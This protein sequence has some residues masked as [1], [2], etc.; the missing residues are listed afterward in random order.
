MKIHKTTYIWIFAALICCLATLDLRAEESPTFEG[1]WR[2]FI[3]IPEKGEMRVTIKIEGNNY[4]QYFKSVEGWQ[5]VDADKSYFETGKDMAMVGWINSGGVWT[6]NQMFSLS[7]VN[8]GKLMVV[9]TRHVTN[10]EDAN[11]GEPWNLRGEGELI[12]VD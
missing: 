6:E 11:D 12:R 10:R 5:A 4:T 2:G 7:Y 8:S 9:W 1:D 3:K